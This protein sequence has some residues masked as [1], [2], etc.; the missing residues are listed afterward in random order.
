MSKKVEL[1]K[2]KE[3]KKRVASFRVF[4]IIL[5]VAMLYF[6]LLV[7]AKMDSNPS[8]NQYGGFANIFIAAVDMVK[9]VSNDPI[10][11]VTFQFS[12]SRGQGFEGLIG[13]PTGLDKFATGAKRATS[14]PFGV[15]TLISVGF[16]M[17][18][19]ILIC[20][21]FY[22][23]MQKLWSELSRAEHGSAKWNDDLKKYLSKYADSNPYKNTLLSKEVSLSMNARK[24]LLNNN[25]LVIGGSG[26]GKTRY[27]VKPNVLQTNCNMV[28]TDP[29][30]ELLE[31]TG[32][33]LAEQGYQIKIF[34]L[35]QMQ[36][37][38]CYNPFHYI[39]NEEGVIMMINCL[40][41]NTTPPESKS[42]DPFWEKSET[43]LLQAICFMLRNHRPETDQNFSTVMELLRWAEVDEKDPNYES[44]L[45]KIFLKSKQQK[46][47]SPF[48]AG[49]A[50]DPELV[51]FLKGM[52]YTDPHTG[53]EKMNTEGKSLEELDTM[54][55]NI[56]VKQYKIFKMGA[57]KTLKSI[58]ISVN[59]RLAAFN[60]AQIARLTYSDDIHLEEFAGLK[61]GAEKQVLFVII[62][63]ADSTFNFLVSMMYSQL[64]ETLYYIAETSPECKG[65]RLPR[66]VKFLLDEFANIGT[67]PEFT[68]KLATMRKYEI[69]CSVILQNL[70]QI[71]TM[72][73]DD[74]ESIVGN[75]DSIVF[76]GGKEMTTL[77]YLSKELGN[78]TIIARSDN[79]SAIGSRKGGGGGGS[80]QRTQRALMTPDELGNMDNRECIVMI[81]GI[82]PFKTPKYDYTSHP[83][84]SKTGDADDEYI[85][86]NKI[87]NMADGVFSLKP[88]FVLEST[89]SPAKQNDEFD[90]DVN[91]P[92]EMYA[93]VVPV[94]ESV[95]KND[96]K[97]LFVSF[98]EI[99][100][101]EDQLSEAIIEAAERYSENEKTPEPEPGASEGVITVADLIRDYKEKQVVP[102]ENPKMIN[103]GSFF[104]T[105]D[106]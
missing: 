34:N 46:K 68:K 8:S 59:V 28:I 40:I 63:A 30:G 24:T 7:G 89:N 16:F 23:T 102:K 97:D 31:S 95:I 93:K 42:G 49:P 10:K 47:S 69:S 11:L 74:W 48:A 82:D 90:I 52:H 21:F 76:L 13:G 75:C 58:L 100:S 62:P 84:Y 53:E 36:K 87:D 80:R 88:S 6:S 65:R 73:K 19:D 9:E 78:Q 67:I 37:S 18:I 94:E 15:N 17:L 66:H 70:A 91:I 96:Y 71:K 33:F 14:F 104:D 39:R 98:K 32:V 85:Y 56:A 22:Y 86:V 92:P 77:E 106:D 50:E 105:D 72:Y 103:Q 1:D 20:A 5:S 2:A 43:A 83:K 57:G 25:V 29:S 79:V 35:V 41:K 4:A 64:F 3:W 27:F 12:G 54:G 60:I 61:K 55:T 101:F 44:K 26:A 99:P 51:G 45:D 38:N 81:R